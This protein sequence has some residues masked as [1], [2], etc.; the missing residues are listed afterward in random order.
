MPECCTVIEIVLLHE[1]EYI[2][3]AY[4]TLATDC[5]CDC[6]QS[7]QS[8]SVLQFEVKEDIYKMLVADAV[9]TYCARVPDQCTGWDIITEM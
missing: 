7:A 6:L 1:L 3:C 4:V 9:T 2:Q 8:C 5:G